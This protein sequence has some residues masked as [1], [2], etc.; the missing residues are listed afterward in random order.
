MYLPADH[1]CAIRQGFAASLLLTS[2][3]FLNFWWNFLA[4]MSRECGLGAYIEG[5]PC[6][7]GGG[8]TPVAPCLGDRGPVALPMGDRGIFLKFPRMALYF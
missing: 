7:P 6:R 3:F 4:Q 8:A 5:G 1:K 2:L